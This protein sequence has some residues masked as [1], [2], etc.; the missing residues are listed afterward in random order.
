MAA[1]S[2]AAGCLF[3]GKMVQSEHHQRIGVGQNSFVDR[4]FVACLVD[5]L[6]DGNR[7]AGDLAGNFWKLSVE[8]WNSSSVPAIP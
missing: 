5:A 6:E 3:R 2:S 4:Q 1:T 8:R 7:M